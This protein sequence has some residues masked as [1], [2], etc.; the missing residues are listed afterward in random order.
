MSLKRILKKG[1]RP[2]AG[3]GNIQGHSIPG[4]STDIRGEDKAQKRNY[5]KSFFS[6]IQQSKDNIYSL[7]PEIT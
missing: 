4:T 6:W 5:N 3:Y 1:K 2:F 7:I